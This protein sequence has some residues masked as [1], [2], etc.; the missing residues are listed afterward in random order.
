MDNGA[1][2]SDIVL[3]LDLVASKVKLSMR[4]IQALVSVSVSVS[5]S[6]FGFS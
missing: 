5:V 1:R 3:H 2:C 6:N 4:S